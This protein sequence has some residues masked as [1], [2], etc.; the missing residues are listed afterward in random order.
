MGGGGVEEPYTVQQGRNFSKSVKN[1]RIETGE[2]KITEAITSGK[3]RNT[4]CRA[5]MAWR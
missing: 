5:N 2:A 3:I 1:L 4:H